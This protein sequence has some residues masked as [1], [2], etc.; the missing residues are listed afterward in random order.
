MSTMPTISQTA[1]QTPA[2]IAE[3]AGLLPGVVTPSS[4]AYDVARAPWMLTID[5]HPSAVVSVR[6]AD[7]VAT[8]MRWA[9]KHSAPVAVQPRGHGAVGHVDGTV[10]VRTKQ[11]K[12]IDIDVRRSTVTVGAGVTTGELSA[13]LAPHGLAYPAGSTTDI[14]VVGM[15]LT[16]GVGW[17]GRA[18]GLACDTIESA[19]VVLASGE[20]RRIDATGDPELLWA[21]RGGGGDFAVVTSLT[22]KLFPA[23]ALWGGRLLWPADRMA[24]VLD[25]F[26]SVTASA[27]PELT[28]WFHAYRFP[29]FPEVPEP[30]RGKDF[31]SVA[32]VLLGDA[33]QG[34]QLLEPFVSI[35]GSLG[36][37]DAL[38]L[39][40]LGAV[41]D[42]PT[43]PTP[44]KGRAVLLDELDHGVVE[45]F[46]AACTSPAWPLPVTQIRHLGGAFRDCDPAGAH[47]PIE[48]PYALFA[49][50]MAIPE[51][52]EP[53]NSAL[54]HLDVIAGPHANHRV[55]L[56]FL[57][58]NGTG[59]D[60]WT[61]AQLDRLH[62][63]KAAY[64]PANL[65]RSN[66][67]VS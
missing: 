25:A 63:A 17:F 23:P 46:R 31:A 57:E 52:I 35:P 28:C 13:A 33:D 50:G 14:S 8:V 12:T 7:D 61:A 36:A 4:P 6:S 40:Q 27:P 20:Q 65:I 64:D 55:P 38:T 15:T 42:E 21:L 30:L 16:G 56:N 37:L 3:L 24:D 49:F 9:A 41:A 66:R 29:P 11:L 22:L 32:V 45:R 10:L 67:P 5:Q 59:A 54:A 62:A 34:R 43:D 47:G 51:M 48:A 60:W 1:D 18:Q 44:A 58:S 2:P 39:D 26:V 53:V 19:D